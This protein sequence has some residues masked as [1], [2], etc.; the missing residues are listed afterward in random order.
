MGETAVK[1]LEV[2]APPGVQDM[3]ITRRINATRDRVFRA[4]TDPHAITQWWG[5]RRYETIVDTLEPRSGGSWRFANRDTNGE[6]YWFHGVYH[7]VVPAERITWTFEYEGIPG[8][9]S[10]E[11]V[12]FE[13][14]G[15]STNIRIHSVFESV[16]DRDGMIQ[17][18]M[19]SGLSESMERLQE[20]LDSER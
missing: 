2:N 9:V 15:D 14:E 17:S 4:Y 6:E 1:A 3:T 18:G 20:L 10:L 16:A 5:P 19:E 11:T 7:D 8:H 13:D 12:T